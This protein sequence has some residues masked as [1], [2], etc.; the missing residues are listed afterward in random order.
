[1]AE[2]RPGLLPWTQRLARWQASSPLALSVAI[3]AALLGLFLVTEGALG[4]LGNAFAGPWRGQSDFRFVLVLIAMVAYLPGAHAWGARGA[5]RTIEELAPVLRCG[6]DE[7]TRLVGGAGRLAPG[8]LR[9]AGLVGAIVMLLVP[10]AVDQHLRT[11]ALWALVPE[12]AFQRLL[13]PVVGWLAGCFAYAVYAES[14]KLSR[15]G[16][17]RVRID[18]LDLRSVKPLSRQGLRYALLTI[19]VV[20]IA[21]AFFLDPDL[22]PEDR[23]GIVAVLLAGHGTATLLAALALALPVRGVREAIRA[24][25]QDELAWCH[26]AIRRLRDADGTP[27]PG[28]PSLADL[29]A[30][31]GLVEAVREW[32]FDAPT[33][34]RFVLYLA[35]PLG[36]WLGGAL[37][38]HVVDTFLG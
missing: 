18:L 24:A 12:T 15:L 13:L 5:R 30:W 16:R 19:G 33:L 14:R 37:V 8:P 20:S 28:G 35:I 29:V 25:K 21:S 1:M 11:Y 3:G 38:E 36:S 26:D 34:L 31:R 17:E 9:R 7:M 32:P 22:R 10:L 4:R 27:P 23:P 2:A 6:P